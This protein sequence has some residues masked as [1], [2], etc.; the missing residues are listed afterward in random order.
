M[1]DDR[2]KSTI[3]S[4]DIKCVSGDCHSQLYANEPNKAMKFK[5]PP[6]RAIHPNLTQ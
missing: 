5:K 3:D 2:G 6:K 4:M 1:T